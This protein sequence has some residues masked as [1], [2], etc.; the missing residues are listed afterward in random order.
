MPG[1]KI[2]LVEDDRTVQL[3]LKTVLEKAGYQVFPALDAMQGIMLARQQQPD[4]IVLDMMMPAGGG[5]SVLDRVRTLTQT[6]STPVLVYSAMAEDELAK[7]V[8]AGP[9]TKVL[10]KPA[11]P[12]EVLAAVQA[13]IGA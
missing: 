1:K 7:K 10:R 12:A 2:L 3:L 5:A 11:P 9:L 8:Q 6:M 4:L 13:L